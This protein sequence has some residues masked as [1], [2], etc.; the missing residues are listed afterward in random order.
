MSLQEVM[1]QGALALGVD[2]SDEALEGLSIYLEV[3]KKWS[4]AK[5]LVGP[6]DPRSWAALH[7]SDAFALLPHLDGCRTLVDIGSGAGLP[8]AILAFARP[9]LQVTAVE[10]LAKR[11]AFLRTVIRE[12][13]LSN[14]VAEHSRDGEFRSRTDF[15]A[16]D[17][18]VSRA[19]WAP[20]LWL[21]RGISLVKPG[22]RVLALEGKEAIELPAG[23]ERFAYQIE[24][25]ERAVL[26]RRRGSG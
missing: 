22:G 13:G 11:H 26:V 25:R 6:G 23:V 2:V 24:G 16:Y 17:A 15:V 14:L 4:L 8:G 19:V 1:R 20:D 18:A 9:D 7:V 10:P 12:L 21:E 3:L 5:N